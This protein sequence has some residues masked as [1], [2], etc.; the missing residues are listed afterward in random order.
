MT[1]VPIIQK[2]VQ[3]RHERINDEKLDA[4]KKKY[5]ENGVCINISRTNFTDV[6]LFKDDP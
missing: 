4:N 2:P 6:F 3:L 1:E 5:K